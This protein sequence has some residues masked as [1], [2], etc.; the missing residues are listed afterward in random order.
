[1]SNIVNKRNTDTHENRTSTATTKLADTA[2]S[3]I[4][5]LIIINAFKMLLSPVVKFLNDSMFSTLAV[6]DRYCHS[7]LFD[8]YTVFDL[9]GKTYYHPSM[10]RI[11]NKRI[12]KYKGNYFVMLPEDPANIDG[13]HILYFLPYQ[14]DVVKEFINHIDQTYEAQLKG[15]ILSIFNVADEK[16]PT[17]S[18]LDILIPT[19][20]RIKLIF[21]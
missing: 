7:S 6:Y 1:M 10:L 18:L 19:E 2:T 13:T 9:F 21:M 11:D 8:E 14:K 20:S 17:H 4:K 3:T 15:H 5:N 16:L 12:L